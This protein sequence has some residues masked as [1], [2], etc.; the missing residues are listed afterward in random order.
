[1]ID[2]VAENVRKNLKVFLFCRWFD[3]NLTLR[4][5][6]ISFIIEKSKKNKK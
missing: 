6:Y 5:I 2:V 1:M 3:A 4:K